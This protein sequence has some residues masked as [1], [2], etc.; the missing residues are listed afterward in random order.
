[1]ILYVFLK[2]MQLFLSC[3]FFLTC[4]M[5]KID[6]SS[7][8]FMITIMTIIIYSESDWSTVLKLTFML[9][10]MPFCLANFCSSL[11]FILSNFLA[12]IVDFFLFLLFS[13][14]LK[15]PPCFENEST[16]FHW[17]MGLIWSRRT[18]FYSYFTRSAYIK[19]LIA[20]QELVAKFI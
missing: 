18:Y 19:Y 9:A 10:L 4:L 20:F 2:F 8:L 16:R 11:Y 6:H 17:S 3:V 14:K 1:M 5:L 13:F 12:S 7:E 15:W